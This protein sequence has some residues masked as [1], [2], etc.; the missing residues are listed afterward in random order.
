MYDWRKKPYHYKDGATSKRWNRRP[1]LVARE[2][3]FAQGKRDDV[4]SPATSG[5]VLKLLPTVFLQ[6][7]SGEEEAREGEGA[8]S[9]ALGCLDVKDAFSPSSTGETFESD[10]RGEESLAKKELTWTES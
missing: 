5:H 7:V 6:R 2:I 3:A 9:Q 8:L 1:R 4:F 10:L